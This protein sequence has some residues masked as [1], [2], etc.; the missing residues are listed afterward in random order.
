MGN[1]KLEEI[2]AF[3]SIIQTYEGNWMSG[4]WIHVYPCL[5]KH[6][7][8]YLLLGYRNIWYPTAV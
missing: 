1:K 2:Q 8:I 5:H 7:N 3:W 6:C 4:I